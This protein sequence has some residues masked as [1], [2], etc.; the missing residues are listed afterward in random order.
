ML[1][2]YIYDDTKYR[3]GENSEVH[4]YESEMEEETYCT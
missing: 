2:L 1:I 3:L 4:E